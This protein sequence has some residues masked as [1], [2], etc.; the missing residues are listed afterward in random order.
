M[1]REY[2]SNEELQELLQVTQSFPCF[3]NIHFDILTKITERFPENVSRYFVYRNDDGR[4]LTVLYRRYI[5]APYRPMLAFCY[6]PNAKLDKNILWDI[7]D[8]ISSITHSLHHHVPV[9]CIYD[10]LASY[11]KEWYNE[12]FTVKA[13]RSNPCLMFYMTQEQQKMLLEEC[14]NGTIS[15]PEEYHFDESNFESDIDVIIDTGKFCN[16][17]DHSVIKAQLQQMPYAL[18]RHKSTGDAVAFEYVL[19]EHRQKGLGSAVEKMV[20]QKLIKENMMP[21]K[22]VEL[23]NEKVIAASKK[24]K[25]WTCW[26]DSNGPVIQHWMKECEVEDK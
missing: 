21:F 14:K 5:M 20:C 11:Y 4:Y 1:L 12:R 19:P 25:Y 18:I 17:S 10:S 6:D 7:F 8:E 22:F 26:K 23:S 3:L 15:L 13:L 9:T 2:Q 24:S 16:K